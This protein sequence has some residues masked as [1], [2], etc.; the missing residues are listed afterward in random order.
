M[1]NSVKN[2]L[3]PTDRPARIGGEW[4]AGHGLLLHTLHPT[5]ESAE[6]LL[7]SKDSGAENSAL[8]R[9]FNVAFAFIYEVP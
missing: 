1:K 8:R 4:E 7:L 9:L 2:G 3:H 5:L 6:V